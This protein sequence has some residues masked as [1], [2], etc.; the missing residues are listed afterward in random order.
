MWLAMHNTCSSGE[1]IS[2]LI[3]GKPIWE[4]LCKVRATRKMSALRVLSLCSLRHSSSAHQSSG[5]SPGSAFT[6]LWEMLLVRLWCLRAAAVLLPKNHRGSRTVE[7]MLAVPLVEN[8][9]LLENGNTGWSV[10]LW[11]GLRTWVWSSELTKGR[12]KR[13]RGKR[14]EK[15]K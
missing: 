8:S 7:K 14:R 9:I 13:E 12:K 5:L 6:S 1:D 15:K 11:P 3:K 10:D 2:G 4:A